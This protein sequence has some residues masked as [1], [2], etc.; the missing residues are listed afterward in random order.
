MKKQDLGFGPARR[1]GPGGHNT[2]EQGGW[3]PGLAA[4]PMADMTAA[5]VRSSQQESN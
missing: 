5:A 4:R 1:R 3:S 2:Q